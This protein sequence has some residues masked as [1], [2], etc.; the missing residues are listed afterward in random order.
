MGQYS[1]CMRQ[2]AEGKVV[3]PQRLISGSPTED[4]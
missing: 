4:A 1:L 3:V 2:G